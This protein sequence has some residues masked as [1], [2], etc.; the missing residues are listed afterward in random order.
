MGS[1]TSRHALTPRE[2][3]RSTKWFVFWFLTETKHRIP[4]RVAQAIVCQVGLTRKEQARVNK[5]VGSYNNNKEEKC[6]SRRIFTRGSF[7]GRNVEKDV[8]LT[9]FF[10]CILVARHGQLFD[11]IWDEENGIV[12]KCRPSVVKRLVVERDANGFGYKDKV[13]FSLVSYP[14]CSRVLECHSLERE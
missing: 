6:S 9:I 7:Y 1:F 2:G 13:R 4:P 3:I 14:L 12:G 8:R 10:F 5:E 11:E